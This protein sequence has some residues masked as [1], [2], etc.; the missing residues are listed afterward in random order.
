[1][2]T[3]TLGHSGIKVSAMGLGC[4]AIGGPFTH[5]GNPSGWSQVDDA[6]S[7]RAIHAGLEAGVTFWDTANVYGCGHRRL[8]RPS[9]SSYVK[10][11]TIYP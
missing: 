11:S 9:S 4:W 10:A 7:I 5:M 1:M 6:E 3:R 2:F 8:L